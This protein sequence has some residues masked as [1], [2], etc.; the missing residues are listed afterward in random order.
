MKNSIA[1]LLLLGVS[2]CS[3]QNEANWWFF[4]INAGLDFNT[5]APVAT[6]VGQLQ[7]IEGCASIAGACG[8]LLFYTDGITV[9]DATHAVMQNGTGLLGDP[10][11]T[12]SAIIIP[13]PGNS[14]IYYIYTVGDLNP[15][16]GLNYSV[17]NMTLNNGMGAIV[18][19]LKNRSLLADC[20]E[21]VTA[22][23]NTTGDAAWIITFGESI[24]GSG[25]F[26][27]FYAF[28][29]T[30]GGMDIAATIRTVFT[31]IQT[32]DRRGYLRI[33]PDGSKIAL[34]TQ[35][36][37]NTTD[38]TETAR[39]AWY[40]N[41]NNATGTVFN[42][43][44]IH[45]PPNLMAY[46]TAF[47]SDSSKLYM[48]LNTVGNG[49]MGDRTLYQYDLNNPSFTTSPI[50]LYTT[51]PTIPEDNV[52]RGALQ[53]GPD[54]IIYYTRK[55]TIWL[56]TITNPNRTGIAAGFNL[57]GIAMAA[58]T[59]VE[60]GLPPF[61]NA[62]FNPSFEF[63]AACT[64]D[65][66]T[67]NANA[68]AR[69]SGSSV[70]WNFDDPAS[71]ASNISILSSATHTYANPGSYT[72]TLTINTLRGVYTSSKVV[73]IV[74]TP[75]AQPIAPI[76]LCD[77]STNDGFEF[78][79]TQVIKSTTLG[80]L[81]ALEYNVSIHNTLQ[82]AIND[83]DRLP[84]LLNATTQRYYARV[85][86]RNA[87]GCYDIRPFNITVSALPVINTIDDL[88]VCDDFSNDG[89]EM[90]HLNDAGLQALGNQSET[91]FEIS[92]HNNLAD[93]TGNINP[94]GPDY[95][96]TMSSQ[97][98][99]LRM[100]NRANIQCVTLTS[101]RIEVVAQPQIPFLNT[102]ELCDDTQRD[103]VELID[104]STLDGQ[105]LQ[106]ALP[107][108]TVS[109]YANQQDALD[110][111]NPLPAF[112]TTG[113]TTLWVRLENNAS[114]PCYDVQPLDIVVHPKPTLSLP[115]DI[116]KCENEITTITANE[117][118]TS[119]VWNNGFTT[120]SITITDAGTYTVTGMD[121]NGCE[122]TASI[123]VTNFEPTRINDVR[124]HQFAIR[125]N[126][127]FVSASGSGNLTYSLDDFVYQERSDFHNLLPGFYTVYARD[128]N[129][130]NIATA[131]AAIIAAPIFF[132]P[133]NDGFHDTWQVIAI[134]TEPDASIY[135]FDRF[136]KLLKQLS[137]LS[138]GWDGT[139]NGNP[140]P[141]SDYW[142]RVDLIDGQTFKGHFTLKR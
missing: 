7:T 13:Q 31:T 53:L 14:E 130:C 75:I 91:L 3:S 111:I 85:A 57:D 108:F 95:V 50:T 68:I 123:T 55:G 76:V 2:I 44:R 19:G 105:I 138:T 36:F 136:G 126:S 32:T 103:N 1:F 16:N 11:S 49:F 60:E 115:P 61:Y 84:D 88:I 99:Y 98:I 101:F 9:W 33:S 54:G 18:P 42:P 117:W 69:C 27:T 100:V 17:V 63:N 46:G 113:T 81:S 139:Y 5:G 119:Y 134:E 116:V 142:F 40:F 6:N 87:S 104:L 38:L 34:V 70:L 10:S 79:D 137:P 51:N 122:D 48:D 41:F 35:G 128:S 45:F 65:V 71:G 28:K 90:F 56:S 131:P 74:N 121:I 141:S 73:T 102:L 58:N 96:N 67:F 106:N 82:D 26:N 37:V 124:I 21:K 43:R 109:Y 86:G 52:G 92:Y 94:I 110:A 64:G 140:M 4:G 135:I 24:A 80:N 30:S 112:Y 125:T 120:R 133:N 127:I 8:D 97:M 39:G 132:T 29:L 107:R 22:A 20:T 59:R 77:D 25:I 23:V 129:G 15:I 118:F 47:S 62:F 93:A 114:I 72:V 12:Q 89:I 83:F 66:S 78:V